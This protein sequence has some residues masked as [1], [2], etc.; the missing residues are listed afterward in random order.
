MADP[1]HTPP[2]D[3]PGRR[4]P[5]DRIDHDTFDEN[6]NWE[7]PDGSELFFH[8]GF[9]EPSVGLEKDGLGS[10]NNAVVLRAVIRL[11]VGSQ[12]ASKLPAVQRDEQEIELARQAIE[13]I[14][15]AS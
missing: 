1:A 15:H 10:E 12:E 4:R 6:G 2:A 5:P 8:S 9:S 13:E 7:P 11:S 3:A 14:L